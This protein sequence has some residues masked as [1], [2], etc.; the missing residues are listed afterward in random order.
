MFLISSIPG[1]ISTKL[2]VI[3]KEE[4]L[5]EAFPKSKFEKWSLLKL[6][7]LKHGSS[8]WPLAFN[9]TYSEELKNVLNTSV[10][11]VASGHKSALFLTLVL[12]KEWYEAPNLTFP[13]EFTKNASASQ[14]MV[15]VLFPFSL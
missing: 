9:R 5:R 15:P 2:V 13:P 12:F 4:G 11:K 3:G 10:L 6:S 1:S 8:N 7:C 14:F